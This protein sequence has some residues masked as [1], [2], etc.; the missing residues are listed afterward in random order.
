MMELPVPP[1]AVFAANDILAIG[2][3]ETA[4]E[5]NYRVLENIV[6]IGFDDIPAAFWVRP[7]L[8]TVSQDPSEMGMLLAKSLFQRITGEYS[9]PSRRYEVPCNFI[10]RK[11]E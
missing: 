4:L 10:K 7:R 8:T 9:E 5:M 1:T 2:A 3:L 6:I 11:S